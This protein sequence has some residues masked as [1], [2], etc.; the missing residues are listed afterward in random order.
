MAGTGIQSFAKFRAQMCTADCGKTRHLD[1][2]CQEENIRTADRHSQSSKFESGLPRGYFCCGK[3][4]YLRERFAKGLFLPWKTAVFDR[5]T[6][7]MTEFQHP[8]FYIG[9]SPLC[10]VI[11]FCC[12]T[13]QV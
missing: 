6:W 4:R 1:R 2:G 3:P 9:S 7:Q 11:H 10:C 12:A 13:F 8:P 5:G